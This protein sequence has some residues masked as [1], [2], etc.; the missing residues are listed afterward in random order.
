ML[1]L[2]W[3]A[4]AQ[5]PLRWFTCWPPHSALST[6]GEWNRHNALGVDIQLPPAW[7][8]QP[9]VVR[10]METFTSGEGRVLTIS[11][12]AMDSGE[13]VLTKIESRGLGNPWHGAECL[14]QLPGDW[15]PHIPDARIR[16]YRSSIR[17]RTWRSDVLLVFPDGAHW[18]VVHYRERWRKMKA[19]LAPGLL[20]QMIQSVRLANFP[21]VEPQVRR[22]SMPD[23]LDITLS[24]LF[25]SSSLSP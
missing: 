5:E 8:R 3:W 22:N 23:S 7:V 21:D 16:A 17:M 18:V 4:E 14:S 15:V 13:D 1:S 10:F 11:R 2:S 24:P 19:R 12:Q 9:K 20:K 6:T 25:P